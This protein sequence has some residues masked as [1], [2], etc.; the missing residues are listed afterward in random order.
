MKPKGLKDTVVLLSVLAIMAGCGGKMQIKTEG[1]MDNPKHHTFTGMNMLGGG[2]T[3]DSLDQFERAIAIDDKYAPAYA[4]KALT[5]LSVKN[6]EDAKKNAKKS[7][8]LAEAENHKILARLTMM[9]MYYEERKGKWLKKVEKEFEEI[10]DI[11]KEVP[12]V[13]LFMGKVYKNELRFS[14]AADMFRKVLNLNKSFV[15]EADEEWKLTQK[16]ER[17]KPGSQIGKEMA[18]VNKITRADIAALFIEEML[19]EKVY[20][21]KRK[22]TYDSGFKTPDEVEREKDKSQVNLPDDVLDHPLRDDI[23]I[24]LGL[25]IRGLESFSDAKFYPNT[26]ISRSNFALMVEDIL[27]KVKDEESLTR[28]FIG[29][30]SPFPDVRKDYYAFNAVM[31]CTTRGILEANMDGAFGAHEPVTGAD[32]LLALRRLREELKS[33]QVSYDVSQVPVASKGYVNIDKQ[34]VA[35][36]LLNMMVTVAATMI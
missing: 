2:R 15:K 32:A 27:V 4:G 1:V 6:I 35:L 16:I 36:F 24:I 3:S 9:Q 22:K 11:S 25:H 13:Y 33:Y 26:P 7:L 30:N 21:V 14:E 10:E 5:Y 28:E 17:A 34:E 29:N 19:L 8:D 31:V 23:K 20:L 18:L 12:A